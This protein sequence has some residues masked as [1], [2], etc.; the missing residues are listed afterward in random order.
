MCK[1]RG[2]MRENVCKM[3]ENAG[4]NVCTGLH[5]VSNQCKSTYNPQTP[6]YLFIIQVGS[7]DVKKIESHAL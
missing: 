7:N 2:K 4:K 5:C 6:I 1:K 3:R